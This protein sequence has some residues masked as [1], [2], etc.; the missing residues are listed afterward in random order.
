[1]NWVGPKLSQVQVNY[2]SL[3]YKVLS[4]L[5]F[6]YT[7]THNSKLMTKL[8]CIHKTWEIDTMTRKMINFMCPQETNWMGEKTKELDSSRFKHWYTGKVRLICGVGI[9]SDKGWKKVIVNVKRISDWRIGQKIVVEQD[10]LNIITAHTLQV[11]F[12]EY[13]KVK[14]LVDLKYLIQ[15]IPQGENIFPGRGSKWAGSVSRSFKGVHGGMA[16]GRL[17]CKV[18][19]YYIFYHIFIIL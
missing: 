9:I 2:D 16:L 3:I 19:Q 12:E 1:M 15:D 18:N 4:Q 14:F 6:Q 17:M 11:G 13:L 8:L 7:Q 10:I 5:C